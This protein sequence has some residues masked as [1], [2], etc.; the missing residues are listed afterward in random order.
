MATA[1]F[2]TQKLAMRILFSRWRKIITLYFTMPCC[3]NQ[4]NNRRSPF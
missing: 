2:A 1:G 3:Y 4:K